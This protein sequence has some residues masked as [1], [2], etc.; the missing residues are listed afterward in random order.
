MGYYKSHL[1]SR[2]QL[3]QL[4]NSHGLLE[5]ALEVGTHQGA[6]AREILDTWVGRRFY[7]VDVWGDIPE[8]RDQEQTLLH[9]GGTGN[10][11][12]DYLI[13]RSTLAVHKDRVTTL[14]MTSQKACNMFLDG[15]L[16]FVYVDANHLEEHTYQ[17]LTS[18]WSKIKPHGILAGHDYDCSDPGFPWREHIQKAVHRFS[19]ETVQNVYLIEET[20]GSPWSYYTIKPGG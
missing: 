17:D 20:N 10:R 6:F 8:Y 18:W 2:R 14:R 4:L 5:C 15:S 3:A 13:Y 11:E 7:C 12:Q 9:I 16:D 1:R 19:L